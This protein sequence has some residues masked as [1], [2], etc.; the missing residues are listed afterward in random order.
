MWAPL[1][2]VGLRCWN[3]TSN[4]DWWDFCTDL[5]SWYLFR[6]LVIGFYKFLQPKDLYTYLQSQDGSLW[7]FKIIDNRFSITGSLYRFTTI[8]NRFTI[9]ESLY[10]LTSIGST[11]LPSQDPQAYYRRILIQIYNFRIL[12]HISLI[13]LILIQIYDLRKQN[14]N[15]RI[16]IHIYKYWIL[17][18]I[19]N[20]K[21]L[22]QN[23]YDKIIKHI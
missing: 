21:I 6:I 8:R 18:Q 3:V 9:I 1:S 11:G 2:G 14:G 15:Y 13:L 20:N 16:L 4:E 22:K 17:M 7:R 10:R 5:K 19:Y 12:R 23:Q